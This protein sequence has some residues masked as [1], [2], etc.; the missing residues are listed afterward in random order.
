LKDQEF[1]IPTVALQ[2]GRLQAIGEFWQACGGKPKVALNYI[3]TI[4]VNLFPQVELP[5]VTEQRLGFT[6]IMKD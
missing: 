1:P 2:P 3:A 5:L 6:S 4:A